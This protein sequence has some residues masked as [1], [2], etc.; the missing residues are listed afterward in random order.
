MN[1][2]L[3]IDYQDG[4]IF[5]AEDL[6]DITEKVNEIGARVIELPGKKTPN[7]GI[8]FNDYVNNTASK[9]SVTI[10]TNNKSQGENNFIGGEK[11]VIDNNTVKRSGVFGGNNKLKSGAG[12]IVAGEHNLLDYQ[13]KNNNFNILAGHQNKLLSG[14]GNILSGYNNTIICDYSI[15]TGKSHTIENGSNMIIAGEG[16][17]V[18]QPIN[19]LIISGKYANMYNS[20]MA[21]LIGGGDSASNRKNVFEVHKNGDTYQKG[22]ANIAGSLILG[23]NKTEFTAEYLKKIDSIENRLNN[24]PIFTDIKTNIKYRPYVENGQLYLEEVSE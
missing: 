3:R 12:N 11:N 20:T 22:N 24:G 9:G 19:G 4:E 13:N 7:G 23:E 2:E 5:K 10:G 1:K 21:F 8:I 17:S 14:F 16:H 6:N 15:I 18:T